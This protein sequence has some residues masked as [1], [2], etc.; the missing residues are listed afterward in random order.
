MYS[1]FVKRLLDIVLSFSA[2]I[3]LSPLMIVLTLLGALI[4]KGSPFF[5][6][7]RP[8]KIGK[9]GKEKIFK[10]IKFR[11]MNNKR[12]GEGN[13]LPDKD[14]LNAYGRFLRT[15]SLDEICELINCFK[16]DMSLV[17]P[18]PLL[19]EYLPYYTGE[20]RRR[21]SVRPGITGLAQVNGRNALSWE[22]RF[23]F[24][25]EYVD[26]I[27]FSLDVKIIIKTVRN[28]LSGSG[29]AEDTRETEGN[30]AQ[31]RKEQMVSN[32]NVK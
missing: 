13:L 10:L 3:V 26:N 15:S 4:M 18:R 29:V 2:L 1:R 11:T 9:N 27:S 14:R 28:V 17:G 24:D 25:V 16:G 31:I 22:R 5:V 6:Q 32:T 7:D 8:G 21:H 12:D 19:T 30:F 20:E 23:A